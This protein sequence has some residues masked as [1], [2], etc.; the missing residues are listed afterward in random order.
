MTDTG[1]FQTWSITLPQH[2]SHREIRQVLE[3]AHTLLYIRRETKSRLLS[4]IRCHGVKQQ[5]IDELN[6]TQA[7]FPSC[8]LTSV[9]LSKGR[10]Q[11]T[12]VTLLS[13][14]LWFTHVIT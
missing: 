10:K 12:N 2:L 6:P 14:L 13:V 4:W 9:F 3:I 8:V 1:M 5:K 7:F 11:K